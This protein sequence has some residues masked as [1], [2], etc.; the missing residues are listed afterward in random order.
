MNATR[1]AAEHRELRQG[2]DKGQLL[3]QLGAL[4]EQMIAL[5]GRIG[6]MQRST[7]WR[8]S[9]PVRWVSRQ[10]Q[11]LRTGATVSAQ[12]QAPSYAE[13]IRLY[14]QPDLMSP[15][16]VLAIAD[17]WPLRPQFVIFLSVAGADLASLAA[18][19][20]AVLSQTYASWVLCARAD[21]A[22]TGAEIRTALARYAAQDAR[23]K[24][25]LEAASDWVLPI[26][27]GDVLPAHALFRI[28]R[29]IVENPQA[30]LIYADEDALDAH[31]LRADPCFKP[32]WNIDLFRA[33]NL[34]LCPGAYARELLGDAGE[35]R[36]GF[37][38]AAY[39]LA[40]RCVE[41]LRPDQVRHIPQ[42]LCHRRAGPADAIWPANA[43]RAR[44]QALSQHLQ[45]IGARAGVAD[46]GGGLLHVRYELPADPPPVTLVIPTRNAVALL[47]QCVESIVLDTTYPDFDILVVDNGS[48]DPEALAYL[49]E[50]N[51]SPGIQVIRD[52][53]PFNY[54]ALNNRA[55][56]LARGDV[57]G[58]V[59][60]D[61]EVI[62]PGWLDEMVSIALQPG[63]GAVGAKLLYADETVQHGG[64]LLGVGGVAAH[65]HKHLPA[66][67][68]GYFQRAQSIQSFS[69]VTAA[70]LVVR[71]ALYQEVGGL[72][73]MNLKVAYNDIDF[74]LKLRAA[75]HRNVWTPHAE[76]FH[77][78][79]AT[80][81]ADV[82][83]VQ[84]ARLI[85]EEA[86]MRQR[87]GD[88]IA[89]DPAYN[90]NL[91][92]HAENFG[93]AWPP[94]VPWISGAAKP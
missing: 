35:W 77:H 36:A 54:A 37:D 75:G 71:K 29:E 49:A 13:W 12:P 50:L 10:M 90:P 56:A 58:L 43:Q 60:N 1:R 32:D 14:D 41:R 73:E 2:P 51:A 83:D 74:C 39:D 19:I 68:S 34:S 94:R 61:I 89:N 76:L 67:H 25:G 42:V 66:W 45:R 5:E 86:C 80:R 46:A 31:S 52:D 92:I 88:L 24:P 38:A 87:W 65:A 59:N 55:V 72:D 91:T 93:L 11:R 84:R 64:V 30:R 26:D 20:D 40:L 3:R 82:S 33:G 17:A 78:E 48:D 85:E 18:T 22:A 79:S 27:A 53:S 28:A 23:I 63:V 62:S 7:S 44:A 9:A 69:A 4:G 6:A 81:G 16:R 21:P 8:I 70:C 57:V 47:R 15:D